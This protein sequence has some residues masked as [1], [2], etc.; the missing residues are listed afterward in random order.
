VAY[1]QVYCHGCSITGDG[2]VLA[3]LTK[4]NEIYELGTKRK[5]MGIGRDDNL[6]PSLFRGVRIPPS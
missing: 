2:S 1:I 3:D 6:S 5:Y 4:L